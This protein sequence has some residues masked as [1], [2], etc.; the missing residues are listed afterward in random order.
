MA[1]G[2]NNCFSQ[3]NRRRGEALRI[4]L[5]GDRQST[6]GA[7]AVARADLFR[8]FFHGEV[9]V[10]G[11]GFT[12]DAELLAIAGGDP[13]KVFTVGTFIDVLTLQTLLEQ[14]VEGVCVVSL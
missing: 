12:D 1:A 11:A 8:E 9:C 14:L 13:G 4:V 2:I 3:L 7:D 5:L 10:V 6:I